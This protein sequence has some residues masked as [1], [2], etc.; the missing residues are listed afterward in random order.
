MTFSNPVM[1]IL[2]G[3]KHTRE[4]EMMEYSVAFLGSYFCLKKRK[5]WAS[6]GRIVTQCVHP[7]MAS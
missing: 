1:D 4:D 7:E 3:D 5:T 2:E 6:R